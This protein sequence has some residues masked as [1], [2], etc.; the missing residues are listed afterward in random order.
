MCVC[1][2]VCVT[3]RIVPGEEETPEEGGRELE[4]ERDLERKRGVDQSKP[5]EGGR[6]R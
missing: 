3:A 6:S 2:C 5:R 1:V 4:R